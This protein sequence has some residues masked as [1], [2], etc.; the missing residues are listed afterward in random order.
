MTIFALIYDRIRTIL[1]MV[2]DIIR[3]IHSNPSNYNLLV[4]LFCVVTMFISVS[5]EFHHDGDSLNIS[6]ENLKRFQVSSLTFFAILIPLAI[7]LLMDFVTESNTKDKLEYW[8]SRFILVS[9][10]FIVGILFIGQANQWF[11]F[12][13]C[14]GASFYLTLQSYT[15]ILV[16]VLCY[17][18]CNLQPVIC[19]PLQTILGNLIFCSILELKYY[20]T[21]VNPVLLEP[22]SYFIYVSVVIGGCIGCNWIFKFY[23]RR[24]K[25]VIDDYKCIFYVSLT[26]ACFLLLSFNYIY[27]QAIS[28]NVDASL[29]VYFLS[30]IHLVL[31]IIP[32]KVAKFEAIAA[33]VIV[34]L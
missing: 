2:I 31:S 25:L 18:V 24:Q 11:Q 8:I 28:Q 14:T 1:D 13:H 16:S 15:I 3:I 22:L 12:F 27:D 26:F 6:G 9:V 10:A 29:S 7:D 32:G 23:Q 34:V 21:V 30:G 17:T 20:A 4:G 5:S 19:T 33:K